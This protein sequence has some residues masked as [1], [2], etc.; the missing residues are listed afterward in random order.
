MSRQFN[1]TVIRLQQIG[2]KTGMVITD[3]IPGKVYFQVYERNPG[4]ENC[5]TFLEYSMSWESEQAAVRD[6]EAWNLRYGTGQPMFGEFSWCGSK[7]ERN[8]D[9]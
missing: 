3:T 8:A 6:F 9:F 1:P 7:E 5:Q 4:G 2:E